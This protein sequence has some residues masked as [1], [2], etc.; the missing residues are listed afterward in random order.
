VLAEPL[1]FT[2]GTNHSLNN[3]GLDKGKQLNK[4]L[5]ATTAF[6]CCVGW[7]TS[8][9]TNMTNMNSF[10]FTCR[11]K[12]NITLEIRKNRLVDGTSTKLAVDKHNDIC[13]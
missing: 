3:G 13:F 7:K 4:T 8:Y 2:H 12:N 10:R 5:L 9:L 6:Q 1:K 11:G